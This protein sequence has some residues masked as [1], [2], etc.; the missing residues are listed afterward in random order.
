MDKTLQ[1]VELMLAEMGKEPNRYRMEITSGGMCISDCKELNKGF[2]ELPTYYTF[3][4]K[5][6]QD[7]QCYCNNLFDEFIGGL[8][9]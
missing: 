8:K 4:N 7:W 5:P 9:A 6:I 2:A 1:I 3:F